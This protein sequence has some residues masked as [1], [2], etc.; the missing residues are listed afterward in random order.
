MSVRMKHSDASPVATWRAAPDRET[1]LASYRQLADTYD[2]HCR[3]VDGVRADALTM[4][5]LREG[6]VVFDVACGT[7][8]M[9]PAL[10][11]AVGPGGAVLGIEQSIEMAAIA[12]QRVADAGLSNTRVLVSPVEEARAELRA[13]ALLF[14]YTHDVLQSGAAL[15]RLGA[16]ARPRARVVVAG[17]RLLGWWAAPLNLWKLWRSRRYLTTYRGLTDPMAKLRRFCPDL[18]VVRTRMLGTSYLAVGHYSSSQE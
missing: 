2:A 13:D 5:A 15:D 18:T 9:L 6:D 17:A 3:W 10:S 11:R 1:A 7:G 12:S 8:A 4:L 14:C 16:L